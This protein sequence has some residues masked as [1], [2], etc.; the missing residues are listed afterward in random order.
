MTSTVHR[1]TLIGAAALA[2]CLAAPAAGQAAGAAPRTAGGKLCT[3]V[4]TAKNDRLIG[5]NG[6]DVICG[7][8]GNDVIDGRGGND[9]ID[10]GTGNDT[11]TAGS[12]RDVIGGGPGNDRISAGSG[13]DTVTGDPGGDRLDGGP[14]DDRL[15]GGH[16]PDD[17]QGGTGINTC[18]RDKDDISA[19]TSCSDLTA[20]VINEKSAHW[21]GPH[22][23]DN[24]AARTLRLRMRVTDDRSGVQQVWAHFATEG[25]PT[26]TLGGN[27]LVSGTVNDGVWELVGTVPAYSPVGTWRA[28]GAQADD[29]LDRNALPEKPDLPSFTVTGIS[30]TEAPVA[31]AASAQWAGPSTFDNGTS[32]TVRLR[33]RVTDDL[34]GVKSASTY[35]TTG[36]GA[37]GVSL[38]A[39]KLVSGTVK[40][41]VWEM[42][43]T[44]PAYAPTGTW[45][46][47]SVQTDDRA[48][49]TAVLDGLTLPSFTV[50]GI[51]DA[52]APVIDVASAQWV[53]PSTFAN[54][55][56]NT[57]RL[58]MHVT[59]DR[60]GVRGVFANVA[61]EGGPV[62]T[63]FGTLVSGT[64]KDGV[65]DLV[66]TLPAFAPAGTW[67]VTSAS[68]T[69]WIRR[70]GTS[71]LTDLPSFTVTG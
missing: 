14:G 44:L 42:T 37:P 69:D 21:A 5:R 3:V 17:L 19:P 24:S 36:E 48:G 8:G 50:T 67:H 15:T 53:G 34:S 12:G 66:G 71:H 7:F 1:L 55:T 61:M 64:V 41:G 26:V 70:S 25:G 27:R 29:R 23:L 43:G 60:S 54:N 58:R 63:L 35:F 39:R 11:I 18:V 32:H 2:G 9:V 51:P 45:H 33:M 57:L 49:R 59:D 68:A 10:G 20:P 38:H 6:N 22:V 62:V 30:D 4:G 46:G 13:N 40:D 52:E 47:T 16:G 28:T 31:D 56:S 65:W